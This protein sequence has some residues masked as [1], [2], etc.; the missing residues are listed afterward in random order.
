MFNDS[1]FAEKIK[2]DEPLALHTTLGVGGVADFY[3]VADS[4]DEIVAF[5][6]QAR[7]QSVPVLVLGGGSNVLIADEGFRG[8]VIQNRAATWRIVEAPAFEG[9][10][11]KYRLPPRW[12]STS[13]DLPELDYN[14]QDYPIVFVQVDSGCMVQALMMQLMSKGITGL[15]C[16]SGI[17]ASIGG[18]IYMN[19]HG[20][21]KYLG[22][23]LLSA[24]VLAN[25]GTIKEVTQSF[26]RFDYDWSVL[27]E[28]NDVVLDAIFQLRYGPVERAR[29]IMTSWLKFKNERQPKKSF[30][31]VFQNLSAAEQARLGISNPGA[32]YVIDKLLHLNGKKMGG[33]QIA[34]NNGNFMVNTGNARAADFVALINEVKAEAKKVLQ[35]ELKEEV[36]YIG[37]T[38]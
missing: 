21:N 24:R 22:D 4:T 32:G 17:P 7:E 1:I 3:V 34:P 5:V 37:F 13:T 25:G 29:A 15:E 33:A 26:F 19:M 27:H 28:T 10:E 12:H 31:S 8:L 30:G 18:G 38:D 14:E 9:K 6:A 35:L 20:A 2:R 36:R 11:Q 16:F 23:L